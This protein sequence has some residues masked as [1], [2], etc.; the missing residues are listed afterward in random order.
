MYKEKQIGKGWIHWGTI[1]GF[2]LGLQIDR[3]GFDLNLI[4]IYIGWERPWH[5]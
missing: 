5:G 3:L 1:R 2:N 4:C